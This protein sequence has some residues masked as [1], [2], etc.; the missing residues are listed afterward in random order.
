MRYNLNVDGCDVKTIDVY[1]TTMD[2]LDGADAAGR[3]PRYANML[4]DEGCRTILEAADDYETFGYMLINDEIV[5]QYDTL[6]GSV[7]D[8]TGLEEFTR[9]CCEYVLDQ[10]DWDIKWNQEVGVI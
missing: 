2:L 9:Y 4:N 5:V 8:K 7:Y 3:F 1:K 6:N 10:I